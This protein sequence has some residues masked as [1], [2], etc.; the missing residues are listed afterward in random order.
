MLGLFN[1][2]VEHFLVDVLY[3]LLPV[4]RLLFGVVGWI[5]DP[6]D[7]KR[8]EG[9]SGGGGGGGIT[10]AHIADFD[11]SLGTIGGGCD[12]GSDGNIREGS[13]GGGG[14]GGGSERGEED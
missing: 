1:N 14:G 10:G 6:E 9:G 2:D 7:C 11:V 13:G 5:D 3:L 8:I 4:L 12:G